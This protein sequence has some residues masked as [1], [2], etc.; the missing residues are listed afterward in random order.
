MRSPL[1][2]A[3]L[4]RLET[5]RV[6]VL[7]VLVGALVGGLSI[8]LR[9][10]LE[11]VLRLG[12]LV[13]GYAPPGTPGEGGLL[14]AFGDALPWGLLALPVVGA[15]YAWLVPA[16]AG[17]A[18]GQLVRGYHARGQWA[19]PVIQL[20]TLLGT[21]LAYGTGL[22][23]GRDSA[24]TTTG[25][26]GA[27]LLGRFTRLDAVEARTLT[28]AGAAAAL[29]AVLHAPLA[30]AVLIAEV[31]Y[32][33]F[34]FEFEV[35]MPCVLAAVAG[36]A[37]Y[38]LAFGFTPLLS[39]PVLGVPSS[40]QLPALLGVALAA[41]LAGWL[42][43][44]AVRAVPERWASGKLRPLLGGLFGLLTAAVAFYGTPAVLGDG[45][46]WV[47][48]GVSDFVGTDGGVAG[49]WR[50]LLLALG[51][52]LAFGGGVLPSVGVG[53]LIGAGLGSLLGVDPALS[54]LIGLVAYLTVTLNVPLAATLLA[55]AWG[56]EALLPSALLAAGLAHVL[57]GTDGLVPGQVASRAQSGVHQGGPGLIGGLAQLPDSVRFIPRR[58]V[59]P[60]PETAQD[61]PAVP[62]DGLP[63]PSAEALPDLP[64]LPSNERELYRRG[65]PPGWRGAR[66]KLLS[67][68]PG[69]E[70]VGLVRDGTVRLPHPEMRLT[71]DD[72]L[73]F[74][75][76]PDAY[77]ALEGL[78]RLPG[79]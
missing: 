70:V 54:T 43:L 5:G 21:V 25:Q 69:V 64:S 36:T 18:L 32:C 14:M 58:A 59:D 44:L 67:L 71:T 7:S 72:E 13:T 62:Y 19:A 40:A 52:R 12:A 68:P 77:A 39:V 6:V 66:L 78:L 57:S 60:A 2:R 22:L 11:A 24:F 49:A 37:V 75:A 4:T 16:A 23:V 51:A 8:L 17:D 48:L 55:V 34:E 41:T 50:W 47:Q 30:A 33:R 31:L 20:R 76:R 65:V 15:L 1:P 56:G 73:V 27:R 26:L 35:V 63:T 9:L 45:S 28:L 10:L 79:A 74:L 46:G 38:G 53:G 29:G 61:A 3:V 42:S